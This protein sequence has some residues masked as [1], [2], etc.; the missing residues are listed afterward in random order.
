MQELLAGAEV[1]STATPRGTAMNSPETHRHHLIPRRDFLATGCSA[2]GLLVLG[3]LSGCRGAREPRFRSY[4]FTLGV[5]SGDPHPDGVVLWTRLA[6]EPR[7]GG[8]MEPEPFRVRWEIATDEGFEFAGG[9]AL[10][11]VRGKALKRAF[12]RLFFVV[13]AVDFARFVLAAVP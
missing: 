1:G 12:F 7:S 9:G 3:S 4:P 11:Q 2:A 6:P 10:V 8:G 13:G 5:G